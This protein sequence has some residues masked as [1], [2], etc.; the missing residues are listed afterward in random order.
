MEIKK[1]EQWQYG[2]DYILISLDIGNCRHSIS[3]LL[4]IGGS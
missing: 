4:H 2:W 3:Y 1:I